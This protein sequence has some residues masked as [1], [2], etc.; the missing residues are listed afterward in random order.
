MIGRGFRWD[1]K[2]GVAGIDWYLAVIIALGAV[3]LF[4]NLG[5]RNIA[6]DETFT[7]LIA[8]N[9]ADTGYPDAHYK[10]ALINPKVTSYVTIGSRTLDTWSSW[11]P[12]YMAAPFVKFFG[13]SEFSEF[14]LRFPFAV[15]G[16][17]SIIL[18]Y[19]FLRDVSGSKIVA[20]VAVLLMALSVTFYLHMRQMR[21]YSMALFFGIAMLY[22]YWRFLER[23]KFASAWFVL[24]SVL[25]FHSNFF[26]FLGVA[27]AVGLHFL[28][29]ELRNI[30]GRREG[31]SGLK[32][33]VLPALL[34]F[35]FTFPWFYITGQMVKTSGVTFSLGAL[36]FNLL[37][38]FYW[39]F[40]FLVPAVFLLFLVWLFF[41]KKKRGEYLADLGRRY[42]FVA[43]MII[44]LIFF[45]SLKS[46][47]LPQMRYLMVMIPLFS[48]INAVVVYEIY[49]RW[50]WVTCL[51]VALLV[52]SNLLNI[53]PMVFMEDFANGFETGKATEY[54][55]GRFL[56][57]TL[58]PRS[59]MADYVYE[60][61]HDYTG[62]EEAIIGYIAEHNSSDESFITNSLVFRNSVFFYTQLREANVSV[63]KPDWI[64][65]RGVVRE[66]KAFTESLNRNINLSE[67][68]EIRL[69]GVD[70]TLWSEGPDPVNH[71]FRSEMDGTI[72]IYYKNTARGKMGRD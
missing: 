57:G 8:K 13:E 18:S 42:G 65:P 58:T 59:L 53:F 26:I 52:F 66:N 16:L 9:I 35:L 17:L 70:D 32:R 67:Y 47:I 33:F 69:T 21:W 7:G 49:K 4:S 68:D 28:V 2:R 60:I 71:R 27:F 64:L 11:L 38:N 15:F 61:S 51:A 23:R 3:L 48:L 36:L 72:L 25:L 34:I 55:K 45:F 56:E 30:L 43:T 40:A 19:Y 63:E 1:F 44:G 37:L 22:S 31:F 54:E 62:P 5:D 10:G 39:I 24:S 46:D 29:F 12:Y 41:D 14:F 50:K 6:A 20:R